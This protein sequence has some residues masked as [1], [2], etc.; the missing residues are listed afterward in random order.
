[1][2]FFGYVEWPHELSSFLRSPLILGVAVLS[3]FVEFVADKIP[4]FNNL[5][6]G[7][8][9]FIR[10]PAKSL[11]RNSAKIA[12]LF[13]ATS[14]VF[15]SLARTIPY[16]YMA[17]EPPFDWAWGFSE[18]MAGVRKNENGKQGYLKKGFHYPYL[19]GAVVSFLL[20]VASFIWYRKR[21]A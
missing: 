2:G 13:L 21:A 20:A 14:S 12:L 4:G 10:I 18:G 1:M 16:V 9:T 3:Y 6:D 15:A 5:W 11:H 8:H 7:I 17:I 19:S